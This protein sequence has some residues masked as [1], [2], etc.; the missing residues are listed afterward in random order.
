MCL[1]IPAKVLEFEDPMGVVDLEEGG[2]LLAWFGDSIPE[3]EAKIG[4]EVQVVP[5]IF[6]EKEEIKVYYSLEKRGTTWGKAPPLQ[7]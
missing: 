6:E 2:R 3:D 4:M 1:A 5:R 7:S